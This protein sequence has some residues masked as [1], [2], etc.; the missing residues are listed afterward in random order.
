VSTRKIM[1]VDFRSGDK[2]F[3]ARITTDSLDLD[4][5]VLVPSGCVTDRFEKQGTIFWNHD[6][7]K[8]CA[9]ATGPCRRSRHWIESD[10]QWAERP[11]GYQGEWFPDFC[12]AMVDQGIVR[13]VSVGFDPIEIRDATKGDRAKFGDEIRRVVSKWALLEWSIAPVQCNPDAIITAVRKG[14]MTPASVKSHLGIDVPPEEPK[15]KRQY[16]WSPDAPPRTYFVIDENG[17]FWHYDDKHPRGMLH[18]P[19]PMARLSERTEEWA[20]AVL[21]K[22]PKR[23]VV[24][25]VHRPAPKP[26]RK[27]TVD[28]DAIAREVIAKVKGQLY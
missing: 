1:P 6:Y 26:K 4:K 8:P 10:A 18:D 19:A 15:K 11:E 5:E 25:L 27:Q 12:K 20:L 2:G 3:T 23:V 24:C 16:F 28:C 9:K 22:K 21:A 17:K 14:L 7:D 13:G